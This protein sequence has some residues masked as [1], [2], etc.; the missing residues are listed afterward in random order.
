MFWSVNS[1][2]K[3]VGSTRQTVTLLIDL[4]VEA[5]VLIRLYRHNQTSNEKQYFFYPVFIGDEEVKY[6]SE[7]K[8]STTEEQPSE[9]EKHVPEATESSV[10]ATEAPVDA[11]SHEEVETPPEPNAEASEPC[12]DVADN[13]IEI[14]ENSMDEEA[15][16]KKLEAMSPEEV[17]EWLLEDSGWADVLPF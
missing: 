1:I 10:E 16:R 11:V 5:G 6:Q 13:V 3:E 4:L 15:L 8:P 9:D 7:K 14:D 17:D 12:E 2:A